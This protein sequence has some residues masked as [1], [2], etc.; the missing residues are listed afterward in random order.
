MRG[1]IEQLEDRRLLS[2]GGA[3]CA[4]SDA[5]AAVSATSERKVAAP[6]LNTIIG[7]FSGPIKGSIDSGIPFVD[8][9]KFS[10][11]ITVV[12]TKYSSNTGALTGTVTVDIN[13]IGTFT[14]K[15]NSK[16]SKLKTDR[17]FS[18]EF[19]DSHSNTDIT[20]TGKYSKFTKVSGNFSGEAGGH[21]T[22]GT[23][24]LTRSA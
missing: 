17:T 11:T 18:M 20:I 2:A 10:G 13:E 6:A 15:L 7:T 12:I 3:A 1:F 21:D 16:K 23:Y 5:A 22:D 4:M 24:S 19:K 9:I 14:V 8:N